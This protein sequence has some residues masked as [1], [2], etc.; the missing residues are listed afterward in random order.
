[1]IEDSESNENTETQS[2]VISETFDNINL[3][4]GQWVN[5]P[6][7]LQQV[8]HE[9]VIDPFIDVELLENYGTINET[10]GVTMLYK[11]IGD[12]KKDYSSFEPNL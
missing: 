12:F 8:A 9:E 6:R 7:R 2:D 3:P 10:I 1:M 5:M 11:A 4:L